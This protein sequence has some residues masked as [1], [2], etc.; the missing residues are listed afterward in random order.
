MKRLPVLLVAV[1]ATGIAIAEEKSLL[2]LPTAQQE[3]LKKESDDLWRYFSAG[4][5][6]NYFSDDVVNEAE[7][8]DGIVRVTDSQSTQIGIGLQAYFPFYLVPYVVSSDGGETWIKGSEVSVGP[9]AGVMVAGSDVIDNF[10]I[11][12]AYSHRRTFGG[13]R[14][15]VGYAFDPKVKRLSDEFLDGNAAPANATQVKYKEESAGAVQVM[16]SFTSGW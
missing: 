15:G 4:F 1:C 14:I 13:I 3:E 10:A 12:I 8:R 2:D 9:Y 5:L 11:G 7:I 6:V 16:I